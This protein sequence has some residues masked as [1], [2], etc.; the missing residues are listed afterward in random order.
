LAASKK[1]QKITNEQ[2]MN[3]FKFDTLDEIFPEKSEGDSF[4]ENTSQTYNPDEID[5]SNQS[6]TYNSTYNSGTYSTGTYS[7]GT[8]ST[9]TDD[10][11]QSF[12]GSLLSNSSSNLQTLI[13]NPSNTNTYNNLNNSN[14]PNNN[15]SNSNPNNNNNNPN[16]SNPNNNPNSQNTNNQNQSNQNNNSIGALNPNSPNNTSNPKFFVQTS[17]PQ[18][19]TR[20][21]TFLSQKRTDQK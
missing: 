11:D 17:R 13:N 18:A 1:T 19:S 2:Y 8:Y 5:Y 3:L 21:Q 9:G 15:N 16:N 4:I 10:A 14:P 7:T 12:H 20:G 6:S